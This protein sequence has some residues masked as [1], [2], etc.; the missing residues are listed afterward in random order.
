MRRH[1]EYYLSF[2]LILAAGL[3]LVFQSK[4]NPVLQMDFVVMLGFCYV[5]WGIVHHVLHHSSSPKIILEYVLVASLGIATMF[6][7]I[8]GGL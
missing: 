2:I 3:F 1:L 7:V 4:G 8:H 6:F 5:A